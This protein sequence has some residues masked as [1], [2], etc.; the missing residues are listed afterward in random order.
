MLVFQ[1]S[2]LQGFQMSGTPKTQGVR[3]EVFIMNDFIAQHRFVNTN[4]AYVRY[5]KV[6]TNAL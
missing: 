4:P 1:G 5:K 6:S 3:L 2:K